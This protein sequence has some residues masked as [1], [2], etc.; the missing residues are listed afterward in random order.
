MDASCH[1]VLVDN[2]SPNLIGHDVFGLW[3]LSTA[4]KR[5]AKM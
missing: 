5:T 3:A 2:K 1:E 4:A